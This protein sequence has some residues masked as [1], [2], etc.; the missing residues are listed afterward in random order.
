MADNEQ[1]DALRSLARQHAAPLG[2]AVEHAGITLAGGRRKVT[3]VL[4]TDICGLDPA[5]ATSPVEP[6]S[7][8]QIAAATR[9]IG[10]ALDQAD[11]LGEAPYTLEVTSPGI[12]RRLTTFAQYRRNTGR[13]LRVRYQGGEVTG[14]LRSVTPQEL[15]ISPDPVRHS[16]GARP[17]YLPDVTVALAEI[18]HANAEADFAGT[19]EEN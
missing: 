7:L 6:V 14:R 4:D 5:D 9:A 16:P 8:D 2:L 15:T 11:L 13:R 3:I 1:G 10:D 17:A 18:S 19:E 12:G